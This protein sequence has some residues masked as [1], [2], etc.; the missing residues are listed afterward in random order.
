[1]KAEVKKKIRNCSK[2]VEVVFFLFAFYFGQAVKRE[3]H[4]KP[5]GRG[6]ALVPVMLFSKCP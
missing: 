5:Q 4:V 3:S 1:M 2:K 6:L